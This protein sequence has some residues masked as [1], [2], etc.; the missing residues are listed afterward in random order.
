MKTAN[1][2]QDHPPSATPTML[3]PLESRAGQVIAYSLVDAIEAPPLLAWPWRLST[4]GYAARS[5]TLDGKKRTIY[6]HREILKVDAG[7]LVDHING[8]RLDNR[9]QNLRI[10]TP[11]ENAANSKDRPRRSGYRGV[12]PHKPTGR[13]IAQISAGGHVRHLG[14]YDDPEAAARAYDLAARVQWG[15]F[16]RTSGFA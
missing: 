12:Y 7:S 15:Q 13:W 14:I 11:A 3:I 8:D 16:A 5:E 9:R 2:N 4:H 1:Q 10:A 6:L